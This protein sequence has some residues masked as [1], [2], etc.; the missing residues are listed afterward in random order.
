MFLA[1]NLS[2]N[3]VKYIGKGKVVIILKNSKKTKYDNRLLFAVIILTLFGYLMVISAHAVVWINY[4]FNQFVFEIGKITVYIIIGFILMITIRNRFNLEKAIKYLQPL[5]IVV[6]V[7]LLG[8]LVFE[9]VNGAKAWLR[10]PGITIQPVEFL[11]ILIILFLASHFGKFYGTKAKVSAIL[12]LPLLVLGASFLFVFLAQNDLGS[13][14]ILIII[15]LCTFLAIPDPKYNKTKFAICFLLLVTVVLFYI[16]GPA[17]SEYIY[18]LSND[19]PLKSQL[20]RIAVLFD[21]LNDVYNTGYQLTNSLVALVDGGLFGSGPGNSTTKFIV[22]E[23]YNDAILS[24]I[25]EE[26]GIFGVLFVFGTYF[27]IISRLLGYAK[28]EQIRITD[29]LI[30]IGIASFFMAQLFVNVGGMV[31]LIPMTGVTLL[32]ISSGGSSIFAAFIAMGI[33]LGVTKRYLK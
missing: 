13:A 23:P 10:L 18:G 6:A 15:S 2:K 30:L 3:N 21:P 26:L 5:S 9:E 1:F 31:G 24:V 20:L 25:V 4:G 19:F 28:L 7:M 14:L 16:F 8:T 29:R 32:F 22:P 17:L 12:R 33:A 27:Y 11:K